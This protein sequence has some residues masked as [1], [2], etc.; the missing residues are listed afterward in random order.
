[1]RRFLATSLNPGASDLI[2]EHATGVVCNCTRVPEGRALLMEDG[3]GGLAALAAA[4][5]STLAIKRRGAAAAIKNLALAAHSD[6]TVDRFV[7]EP[8]VLRKLLVRCGYLLRL[9]DTAVCHYIPTFPPLCLGTDH[10]ITGQANTVAR[11][12]GANH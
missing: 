4:L 8:D 6:G 2:Y 10:S 1:M 9:R 12:S 11:Y 5:L 7:S 3:F